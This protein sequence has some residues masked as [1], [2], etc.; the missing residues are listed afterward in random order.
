MS[1]LPVRCCRGPRCCEAL[2][3]FVQYV[4]SPTL[5]SD[6]LI[7]RCKL[8]VAVPA[9]AA[10]ATR[11]REEQARR[12]CSDA[13]AEAAVAAADPNQAGRAVQ[14]LPC[15]CARLANAH[16]SMSEPAQAPPSWAELSSRLEAL[17][18][19]LEVADTA[20]FSFDLTEDCAEW[21]TGA[22]R[23]TAAAAAAAATHAGLSSAEREV[24]T[25]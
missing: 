11:R 25:R 15:S 2:A 3:S 20:E 13:C 16:S 12:P 24:F 17:L 18:D 23:A 9:V 1:P 21:R 10:L 19:R 8:L 5:I 7:G 4:P 22:S 6:S 14:G